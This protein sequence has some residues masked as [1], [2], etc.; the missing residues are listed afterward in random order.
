[1][2]LRT[3]KYIIILPYFKKIDQSLNLELIAL[4]VLEVKYFQG[5]FKYKMDSYLA[6]LNPNKRNKESQVPNTFCW[7]K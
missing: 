6:Y 2:Y 1:M 5:H 7:C 4:I 3:F